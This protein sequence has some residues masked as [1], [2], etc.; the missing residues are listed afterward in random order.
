MTFY[1]KKTKLCFVTK[2]PYYFDFLIDLNVRV[3][4][5]VH[6]D[7]LR[8]LFLK[9]ILNKTLWLY[10]KLLFELNFNVTE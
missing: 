5:K 3:I 1:V 8:E 2:E 6:K 10:C 9:D 7:I 4:L